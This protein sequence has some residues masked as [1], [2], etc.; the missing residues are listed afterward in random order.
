MT[1]LT[2]LMADEAHGGLVLAIACVLW[3]VGGVVRAGVR[4]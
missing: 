2:W 4:G 3:I 1:A